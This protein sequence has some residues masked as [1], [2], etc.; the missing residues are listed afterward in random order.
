MPRPGLLERISS[1]RNVSPVAAPQRDENRFSADEWISDYLLPSVGGQFGYGG[2]TYPF[3]LT[4]TMPGQR[5]SEVAASLPGHRMALQRCPPAFAAQMV[6]ALVLS[7]ARFVWRNPPWNAKTP[8]RTFGNADLGILERPWKNATTGE[9]LARME[10][11]CG[12]TGNSY[13][14]R[15]PDRLRVLR[16]DWV[17]LVFGSHQ[18]PEDA[19]N[20]LDGDLLGYVYQNGGLGGANRNKPQTL[21]PSEIAHWSPL[22]DPESV[23]IGMSWVTPAIRDIQGDVAATQHKLQFFA[24]AATPNLVIKGIPAVNKTEFDRLVA[25]M[26]DNHAGVRNAYKTL[27]LTAGADATVVGA[28][29]K[30]MDFKA[31]QGG[32]ETRIALLS[33]VPA[34]LLGIAE[35]LAGSSLNAGNFGMARR[36]FADSWIYPTLQDIASTLST[37]M[38][39]PSDAELWFDTA[40]MPLLREDAR[41]AADIEGIKATT[42][43]KYVQDGFTPESA[44]AAVIGQNVNLLKHTGLVSVQLL[45]PGMGSP[46]NPNPEQI[47][48]GT[49]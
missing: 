26:E 15:Q 17:G 18:E 22:P 32:G 47:P 13:V 14:Y 34:P 4:T 29:L 1:A 35:G 46:T 36:I 10:W 38:T 8:R 43:C 19:A 7:Q 5:I 12:L 49:N 23:G 33:R 3:G 37:I 9:L 6:R 27:Y 2:Q 44:V 48:A 39:V 16:P 20:A 24:N 11:H 45:P 31:V 41:D 25:M 28:D 40:D 21:L 42:I 30:Q